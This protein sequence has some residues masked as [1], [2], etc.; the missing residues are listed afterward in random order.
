[1]NIRS[2]S[3][4]LVVLGAGVAFAAA[5][6]RSPRGSVTV[7]PD[8]PRLYPRVADP[9][10]PE[11]TRS[12]ISRDEREKLGL[13]PKTWT[14][15]VPPEVYATLDRLNQT[16]ASLKD[17]LQK[18]RDVQAFDALRRIRFEGMVYVQVQLKHD[19]KGKPDSEENKAA[20]RDV[21][22]RVLASLKA[23][24]FH[25]PYLFEK[26][27][28][29]TGYVTKEGLDKLAKK[30]DV[31]GVCLDDKPLPKKGKII[32]KDS[33]PPAKPG[34]AANEPGVAEGIVDPDVYRAF[35][36]SDRVDVIVSLR[37]ES[38]PELGG[39]TLSD[40]RARWELHKQVEKQLRE[41]VLSAMT[42]D[43]FW[44]STLLG[45][46]MSGCITREGLQD[47][48]QHPAVQRIYLQE[49]LRLQRIPERRN[50]KQLSP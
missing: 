32:V 25:V 35:D 31:A 41:R 37:A 6:P 36:L 11:K 40:M 4:C 15:V 39:N 18:G 12:T 30:P 7:D 14:G 9:N 16:V 48:R 20:I 13:T 44:V 19:P 2:L 26:A 3:A 21:Q 24:E 28:G 50:G 22:R 45:P 49:F 1:M 33:L 23:S 29:L 46:G 10:D 42:A 17:R 8:D 5:P 27:P 34:E 38:L 47:L 43:G